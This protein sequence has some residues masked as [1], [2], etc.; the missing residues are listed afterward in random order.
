MDTMLNPALATKIIEATT[1]QFITTASLAKG[2][3]VDRASILAAFDVIE[4]AGYRVLR[5]QGFEGGI[6]I[7][8]RP[9]AAGIALKPAGNGLLGKHIV[10]RAA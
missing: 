9:S 4:A 1:G 6:E 2:L 7:L 3:K 10:R 5:V 8:G